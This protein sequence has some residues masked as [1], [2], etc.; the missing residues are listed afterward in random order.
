[1][2]PLDLASKKKASAVQAPQ[3][4]S[5]SSSSSLDFATK[6]KAK[7]P[8]SYSKPTEYFPITTTKKSAPTS[9]PTS[10][11]KLVEATVKN[12]TSIV[13][14]MSTQSKVSK[15]KN[16]FFNK[17]KD[18]IKN[19]VK[20][21]GEVGKYVG[22]SAFSFANPLSPVPE[23]LKSDFSKKVEQK[24]ADVTFNTPVG[25]QV[26]GAVSSK[27]QDMPIKVISALS[28]LSPEK[29]YKEAFY[30]LKGYGSETEDPWY[31]KFVYQLQNSGGQTALG[32]AMSFIPYAGKPLSSAYWAA[33]SASEQQQGEEGKVYSLKNIAIDTVGDQMLG[34]SL[35]GLFKAGTKTLKRTLIDNG[36][37]EGGTEVLQSLLKMGNDFNEASTPEKRQNIIEKAKEYIVSGDI[38]MEFA[39]GG[40]SGSILSGTAYGIDKALKISAENQTVNVEDKPIKEVLKEIA[41]EKK[42]KLLTDV[43]SVVQNKGVETAITE[44]QTNLDLTTEQ[45]EDLVTLSFE[46]PSLDSFM[47]KAKE[48]DNEPGDS[49]VAEVKADVRDILQTGTDEDAKA[50]LEEIAPELSYLDTTPDEVLEQMAQEEAEIQATLG[51]VQAGVQAGVQ[52]QDPVDI[53]T[54]LN[55]TVEATKEFST[56]PIDK[57]P[58]STT[59]KNNENN[60]ATDD[61]YTRGD[62]RSDID[63]GTRK[64]NEGEPAIYTPDNRI[65]STENAQRERDISSEMPRKRPDSARGKGIV[66][67]IKSSEKQL[68]DAYKASGPSSVEGFTKADEELSNLLTS[69]ELAEKGQRIFTDYGKDRKVT[70]VPSTFPKWIPDNMRNREDLDYVLDAISDVSNIKYPSKTNEP[71]KRA[72]VDALLDQ[73]DAQTGV[74]TKEIRNNIIKSYDE[75]TEDIKEYKRSQKEVSRSNERKQTEA[76]E[77]KQKEVIEDAT[78]KQE[79]KQY[80]NEEI[81]QYVNLHTYVENGEVFIKK[82]ATITEQDREMVLSYVPAGGKEKQ[83]ATGKG[84]LDEYYTPETVVDMVIEGLSALGAIKDAKTVLEPSIGIGAFVSSFGRGIQLTGHEVNPLTSKIVKILNPK[85]TIK[86]LPFEDMFIDD[87]GNKKTFEPSFDLV[88]GNPPYGAHRGTYLGLGEE[89]SIKKY[90]DYFIKRSLDVTKEGGHV[91]LVVPSG[92][93]RTKTSKAKEL[94]AKSGVLVA[95]YRLPNGAFDTTDIG[96]DILI[97]KK[98]KA[99]SSIQEAS[100][101]VLLVEDE[102]F[103]RN[104]NHI[105][106]EFGTRTGRFGEEEVIT[107]TLEDAYA[108]FDKYKYKPL[109]DKI[110]QNDETQGNIEN[111]IE[112]DV[113]KPEVFEATNSAKPIADIQENPLGQTLIDIL[114]ANGLNPSQGDIALTLNNEPYMPLSIERTGP[115]EMSISHYGLQNGDVMRDPEIV[116]TISRF[117]QLRAKTYENSYAGVYKEIDNSDPFLKEWSA[118]LIEQGFTKRQVEEITPEVAARKLIENYVTRGDSFQSIKS[119]SI[120]TYTDDF[121]ASVG[122]YVNGKNV[123]NDKIIVYK[124]NGKELETPAIISLKDMFDKIKKENSVVQ[125]D[126]IKKATD[127][128]KKRLEEDG[129]IKKEEQKKT[130][131]K[132]VYTSTKKTEDIIDLSTVTGSKTAKDWDK[133]SATGELTG[134][135]DKDNAFYFDGKY[136]NEFNYAKGNIYQKLD[137]LE[138]DKNK[139]SPEQY[140]KQKKILEAV[141]P[142]RVTLARMNISPISRFAEETAIPGEDTLIASFKKFL[143]TL[144]YNAFGQSSMYNIMKYIEGEPV[145]GGD[146]IQNNKDRKNR[147]IEGDKLFAKFILEELSPSAQKAIEEAYNRKFNAIYSPDYI[148]VPLVSK[149]HKTFA[150]GKDFEIRNTQKQ[151]VGFLVNKG[152]GLLAHDVGLGK[153]SAGIL[154]I[155]ETMN[156]GWAKKPLVILPSSSVYEQWV[157]EMNA[158]IPDVKIN[159]LSNLGGDFKS[160]LEQLV[161]EDGTISVITEEGFKKLGFKDETYTDLTSDMRD[162]IAQPTDTLRAAELQKSKIDTTIGTGKKGTSARVFFEDLGFDHITV[163]EVHNYN[164]IVGKAKADEGKVSEFSR[165]F[166]LQPSQAGIKLWLASQ[167]ILKNNNGRN[168]VLLSATP[169]TNHPLEYYSVL[170]LMARDRMKEMGIYNVND[171]MTMF[172]DISVDYEFKADGTYQEKFDVRGFKNYQQLMALVTEFIDFKDGAEAGIVRP[173]KHNK[174]YVVTETKNQI[175]YKQKAQEL[176][177]DKKGGTL[178]AIGELRALAFSEYLSRYSSKI[179]TAKEFVENTPKI[180]ATIELIKQNI[181][182][183]SEANSIIYSPVGVEFFPMIKKYMVDEG[184]LLPNQIEIISGSTPKPKRGQVQA[185]F[186]AGKVKVIIGSDSIQEGI[187]LQT[188]TSDIYIL[189]L[190]W[191]FTALRQ[192][193]GR[194]WRYG[195]KFPNIRINT[196]FVENSLDIFLSQKLQNKEKRYDSLLEFKGDYV[197]IS[198]IDF[199]EMKFDLITDPIERAKLEFE[200]KKQEI[201]MQIAE[202]SSEMAFKARK[203]KKYMDVLETVRKY[204]EY[205]KDGD[206]W[207]VKAAKEKRDALNKLEVELNDQGV[208]MANIKADIAESE[209]TITILRDNLETLKKNSVEE[210]KNLIPASQLAREVVPTDYAKFTNELSEQNKDF[211]KGYPLFQR[212]NA[213]IPTR[214]NALDQLNSLFITDYLTQDEYAL[215]IDVNI[216]GRKATDEEAQILASMQDKYEAF[217]KEQFTDKSVLYSR[218]STKILEQLKDKEFVSKQYIYDM[219]K[220][221]GV[222]Q[223]EKDALMTALLQFQDGKLYVPEFIATVQGNL[224]DVTSKVT[225]E[226]R[227]TGVNVDESKRGD[228]ED[229]YEVI[230]EVPFKTPFAS[231]KHW[232]RETENYFAHERI[233]DMAD[234]TTRRVIEVQSDL[235]QKGTFKLEQTGEIDSGDAF[236]EHDAFERFADFIVEELKITKDEAEE[237]IAEHDGDDEYMAMEEKMTGKFDQERLDNLK[238]AEPYKNTWHELLIRK[239]I[240]SS[241]KDGYTKLQYPTGANA[242][243]IEGLG[244]ADSFKI[245]KGDFVTTATAENIEVG[246]EVAF[247][248]DMLREDVDN[249]KYVITEVLEAGK[250][251]AISKHS[252]FPNKTGYLSPEL[253]YKP[254]PNK[255]DL[256]YKNTDEESFD[257]SGKVDTNNPIYKYYEST[258]YNYLKKIKEVNRVTD[259]QGREWFEVSITKSDSDPVMAFSK[260]QQ[261]FEKLLSE[262]RE[263]ATTP[264]DAQ[265]LI[266]SISQRHGIKVPVRFVERI[267]TGDGDTA[268]GTYF[269]QMLFLDANNMIKTTAFHELVHFFDFNWHNID[270]L[271]GL[272]K[273]SLYRELN[274]GKDFDYSTATDEEKMMI[275]EKLAEL[276][277]LYFIKQ[278][279]SKVPEVVR[280]FFAQ[281]RILFSRIGMMLKMKEMTPQDL[282]DIMYYYKQESEVQREFKI[283]PIVD[284]M[285]RY[286]NG[287][288]VVDFG[289]LEEMRRTNAPLFQKNRNAAQEEFEA[290]AYVAGPPIFTPPAVPTDHKFSPNDE[291]ITTIK[292]D[293]SHAQRIFAQSRDIYLSDPT[294]FRIM[295]QFQKA[296]DDSRMEKAQLDAS[297]AKLLNP[298]IT[299]PKLLKKSHK[300]AYANVDKLLVQGDIDV[301]TYSD[302]VLRSRGLNEHE[303]AA[304][305]AVRKAFDIAYDMNLEK[306]VERG[307]P[308]E[309]I[310]EYRKQKEGYLPHRWE[311]K[312]N[313][314]QYDLSDSAREMGMQASQIIDRLRQGENIE[315]IAKE[316]WLKIGMKDSYPSEKQARVEATKLLNSGTIA[317]SGVDNSLRVDFFSQQHLNFEK[318]KT[319]ISNSTARDDIKN[320]M[321]DAIRDMFKEKGFGRAYMRRHNIKGYKETELKSVIAD[322]FS[323]FTGYLTKIDRGVDYYN[324]LANV[325][326]RAQPKLYDY[327]VNLIAYDMAG[328]DDRSFFKT[329]AFTM[330]LANDIGFLALNAT[331]NIVIGAGELSKLIKSPALKVIGPEALLLKTMAQW[332]TGLGISAHERA[333]AQKLVSLGRLGGE[334]VSEMMGFKN[335]PLYNNVTWGVTKFLYASTSYVETNVNRIPAFI[336]AYRVLTEQGESHAV[337][338]QHALD[339]SEDVNIRGG[340]HNRPLYMRGKIANNVFVF[341]AYSRAFFFSLARD[342]GKKEFLS[343]S[344]KMFWIMA[345]GGFTSLPFYGLY[346]VIKQLALDDDDDE[347]VKEELTRW[348]ILIKK[349]APAAFAQIDFSGRVGLEF[350]NINAIIENPNSLMSYLGAVGSI[351]MPNWS[352]PDESGRFQKALILFSQN[353]VLE[354]LGYGLPDMVG[355]PIKAFVGYTQGVSTFAG[356]EL[357]DADGRVFKY[358]AYEALIKG[359]G[360][361]PVRESIA[362]EEKSQEIRATQDTGSKRINVKRS[363]QG[364]VKRG[365]FETAREIQEQALMDGII[366]EQTDYIKEYGMEIFLENALSTYEKSSKT[367]SDKEKMERDLLKNIYGELPTDKQIDEIKKEVE[368]YTTFGRGNTLIEDIQSAGTTAT[369]VRTLIDAKQT[370]TD[371]EFTNL[372]DQMRKTITLQSGR[373][374]NI[375]LSDSVD[376]AFKKASEDLDAYMA[377]QSIKEGNE[378]MSKIAEMSL[379]NKAVTY[380]KAYG[381]DPADAFK[382]LFTKEKLDM[383]SGDSAIYVRAPEEE[384]EAIR[385][386]RGVTPENTDDWRLDHTIPRILGGDNSVKNLKLVPTSDHA[387]Y[388]PVE[389]YLGSLLGRGVI[390]EKKAQELIVKFKNGEITEA[391]IYKIK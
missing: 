10:M 139:I 71:K 168:M 283:Q 332:T 244:K 206:E 82:G 18:I 121:H 143:K 117:G 314:K 382:M 221:V 223:A 189:S 70:G 315:D 296:G 153:T 318:M 120:G 379:I 224:L 209:S 264:Q 167:Y 218:V 187:N 140:A 232:S 250:F 76:I 317:A 375:L 181:A 138:A 280:A 192:V 178:K 272:S 21:L 366:S 185:D 256:V 216:H 311:H 68:Q 95:A 145:R 6:D 249:A 352:N 197:D 75:N 171:F 124:V 220:Q 298:Y 114:N 27:T 274:D 281:L 78:E 190:P 217:Y 355:N 115:S 131:P 215:W 118:N 169:F 173:A 152:V 54:L 151:G 77:K 341:L 330:M 228:V 47:K 39:V 50:F 380:A 368:I 73:L 251:K 100:R 344:R 23:S 191:N 83:G 270:A 231:R 363:V 214:S 374:S 254:V 89:S 92:F 53:D 201:D 177:K 2:N 325:S 38:L 381:V 278:E 349:G 132:I 107:G 258:V 102:Y 74:D 326:E 353:R 65:S 282:F 316:G 137:Q 378:S 293:I 345:L 361:T 334:Q 72:F 79:A 369:K 229:Y 144:P 25:R 163:D 188:R 390:K 219:T 46:S 180:K 17:T 199:D 159:L 225:E 260:H 204:E 211:F 364:Y 141:L 303:I 373:E 166:Q 271:K 257:I 31:E 200:F 81:E 273:K 150:D 376:K 312:Y 104:V 253:G 16:T 154:A 328:G 160:D 128:R 304:Y 99:E 241:S 309:E 182:D 236:E 333:M 196:M 58:E 275:Q 289:I 28:A 165:G 336:T 360:F 93:L 371:E 351:F 367:T 59:I 319:V 134:E 243:E 305:K 210:I 37:V 389:K 142:E 87:R 195:N 130:D 386:A 237:W 233:E 291:N 255:E 19:P 41:P 111:E 299:L 97:F 342:M 284:M 161:I 116:F 49:S 383:V 7:P 194:G 155:H 377:G 86:N 346:E 52:A 63:S 248:A 62:V 66:E 125:E 148:N 308:P 9:A 35:E 149:I 91:A 110:A 22:S 242:L 57:L 227:Y 12:S 69:L 67:S 277:E 286:R 203:A 297:F 34:A 279:T 313:V 323:G 56:V 287:K 213:K 262:A 3:K 96:T 48:Y 98:E 60:K 158:I 8:S 288:L 4:T 331:Q 101:G 357:E 186:N 90:E 356:T 246:A 391:E 13:G 106:G 11:D 108:L 45:A 322:Y 362:W 300:E 292:K 358:N 212:S 61:K 183:Q 170:S 43:Q 306:M 320:G 245:F 162:A 129:F 348:D 175:E 126:I 36:L 40:V 276:G 338:L 239:Q 33:L 84:L 259:A 268:L 365:D 105:L 184:I 109:V 94:I 226:N 266:D 327:M 179:P 44:A 247:T 14:E 301:K 30:S 370:M 1:M 302:N 267:F 329:A 387:R 343:L 15:W 350:F 123:G 208:N 135:F 340:R 133:V 202:A 112:Q 359:I 80:T 337:A 147:R 335:N 26:V 385:K 240:Q 64:A 24:L 294:Q 113:Y 42:K 174:E 222:K 252:Q 172:M 339:F 238:K 176:F 32:V 146:K 261:K 136:Y 51:E 122:G 310:L 290:S 20:A 235:F 193:I 388:T 230:H 88:I 85:A 103:K 157:K 5:A 324:T 295:D 321:V 29:T 55:E 347:E 263:Y 156:R 354:G 234:S 205:A 265:N 119:G 372:Y 127:A 285:M 269:E 207:Y 307:T 384:T 198:D 164:H